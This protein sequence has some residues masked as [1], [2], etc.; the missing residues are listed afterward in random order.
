[1][2]RP[3]QPGTDRPDQGGVENKDADEEPRR[4]TRQ[5]R[6]DETGGDT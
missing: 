6:D 1:M 4:D 3:G 2:N 5:N